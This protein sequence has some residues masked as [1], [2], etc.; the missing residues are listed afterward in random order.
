MRYPTPAEAREFAD[1]S[2]DEPLNAELDDLVERLTRWGAEPPA[3]P[4][5]PGAHTLQDADK[6]I[7]ALKADPRLATDLTVRADEWLP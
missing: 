2:E 4:A 7:E 5:T 3:P 1:L 6:L